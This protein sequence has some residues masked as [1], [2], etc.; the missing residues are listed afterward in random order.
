MDKKKIIIYEITCTYSYMMDE[1]GICYSL[2]PWGSNTKHYKGY[3]DGGQEYILPDGYRLAYNKYGERK[4]F[5]PTGRY[6]SIRHDGGNPMLVTPRKAI[7][8]SRVEA[9]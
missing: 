2:E 4:I 6:V 5:D 8:L 1:Q 3:D 7:R 9:A